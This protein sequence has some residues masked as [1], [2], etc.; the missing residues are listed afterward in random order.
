MEERSV[1]SLAMRG[2]VVV[3]PDD[4]GK[5]DVAPMEDIVVVVVGGIAGVP[6]GRAPMVELGSNGTAGEGFLI[7]ERNKCRHKSSGISELSTKSIRNCL[8]P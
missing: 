6:S 8:N 2:I 5:V 3:E 1:V 4:E 7:N